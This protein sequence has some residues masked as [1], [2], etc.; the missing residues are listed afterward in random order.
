M[1][2]DAFVWCAVGGVA[3]MLAASMPR[4]ARAQAPWEIEVY[5]AATALPRSLMIELHSNYNF[6]GPSSQGSCGGPPVVDDQRAGSAPGVSRSSAAGCAPPPFFSIVPPQSTIATATQAAAQPAVVHSWH[7]TVELVAGVGDWAELGAYVFSSADDSGGFHVA[8]GSFRAKAR[9]PAQWRW[10]VGLALSSEIEHERSIFSAD[11]WSWEIRPVID[12][13]LGRWYLSVN[14]TVVRTLAGPG[15]GNGLQFAPSAKASFDFTRGISAG[16]E[17]YA[18][19]GE[20]GAFPPTNSQLQQLFAAFDLHSSPV[21][22]VNAGVG[23]GITPSTNQ[24]M[25]KVLLGR[26]LTW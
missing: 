26:R 20:L 6:R 21:W 15:T 24:L 3:L 9:I 7:E 1:R 11:T 13:A 2:A 19:L 14:P 16:L 18:S 25:A 10:P 22:E 5:A 4:V 8:G 23:F 12:K 17:Y